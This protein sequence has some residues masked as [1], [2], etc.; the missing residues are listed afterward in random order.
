MNG[1]TLPVLFVYIYRIVQNSDWEKLGQLVI[2]NFWQG[3]LWR[4][5]NTCIMAGGKIWQIIFC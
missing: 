2:S 4:M 3:K 1:L 5:L